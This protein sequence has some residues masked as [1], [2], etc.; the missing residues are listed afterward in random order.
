MRER[1][2]NTARLRRVIARNLRL[3]AEQEPR[4]PRGDDLERYVQ[5]MQEVTEFWVA[6]H[7]PLEPA[8]AMRPH[9]TDV[10]R[11]VRKRSNQISKLKSTRAKLTR[12]AEILEKHAEEDK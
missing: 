10:Y 6:E 7:A 5:I 11:T 12:T 1:W 2:R 9:L 4:R 3:R 8:P